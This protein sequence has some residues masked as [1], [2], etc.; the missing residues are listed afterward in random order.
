M[1]DSESVHTGSLTGQNEPP[2]LT[3]TQAQP[4][5]LIGDK[6]RTISRALKMVISAGLEKHWGEM[7]KMWWA[8]HQGFLSYTSGF[9]IHP[10]HPFYLVFHI[11]PV[12]Y[13]IQCWQANR[14]GVICVT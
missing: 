6:S 9:S 12:S 1:E 7:V 8:E 4:S 2:V 13:I 3:G 10:T 11:P 5:E 14:S